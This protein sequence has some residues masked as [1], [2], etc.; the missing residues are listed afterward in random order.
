MLAGGKVLIMLCKCVGTS[1]FLLS[2]WAGWSS[3]DISTAK[4]KLGSAKIVALMW[5]FWSIQQLLKWFGWG[6]HVENKEAKLPCETSM[7]GSWTGFPQGSE[8]VTVT[9][10]SLRNSVRRL[11]GVGHTCVLFVYSR[12][13]CICMECQS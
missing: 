3:H 1:T 6:N 8:K 2:E 11:L 9:H 10:T 7:M 4:W 12:H 5:R 13:D